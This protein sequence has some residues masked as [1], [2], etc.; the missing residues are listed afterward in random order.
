MHI[1]SDKLSYRWEEPAFSKL[2]CASVVLKNH[3]HTNETSNQGV[4]IMSIKHNAIDDDL[5]AILLQSLGF[6]QCIPFFLEFGHHCNKNWVGI[7]GSHWH[8]SES[9]LSSWG[10]ESKFGL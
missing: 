2:R 6:S 8:H 1:Q 7:V 10:E 5:G 4:S 3:Q 9:F